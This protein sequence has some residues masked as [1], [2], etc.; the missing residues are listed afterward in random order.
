MGYQP[1]NLRSFEEEARSIVA[2]ARAK[3]RDVLAAA[4]Q[5]AAR[6]RDEAKQSG[7]RE[8]VESGRAE[9]RAQAQQEERAR[10]AAETA[11]LSS[12]LEGIA[13]GIEE[14]RAELL[15]H[16]ERDLVK[17]ALSIAEKIVKSEVAAGKPVAPANVKRAIELVVRRNAIEVLLNPE[18][19]AQIQSYLPEL[20]TRFTDLGQVELRPTPS[21]ARGGCVVRTQ[22]GAVDADLKTQLDEIERTLMG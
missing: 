22:Q 4:I 12:L 3:A 10:I 19:V 5:E 2:Q 21:V 1:L 6:I 18:D 20:K 14:K 15:T 11:G 7:H 8:G 16:A 17:L 9:G 13:R